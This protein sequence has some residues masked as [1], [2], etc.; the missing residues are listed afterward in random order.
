MKHATITIEEVENGM[1]V[2]IV[3]DDTRRATKRHKTSFNDSV[4]E[5]QPNINDLM[6]SLKPQIYIATTVEDACKRI[7]DYFNF[8]EKV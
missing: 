2:N 3:D 1:L 8:R 4:A 7:S 6:A 5:G